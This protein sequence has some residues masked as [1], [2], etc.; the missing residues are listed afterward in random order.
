MT[1]TLTEARVARDAGVAVLDAYDPDWRECVDAAE[2]AM[3]SYSCCIM[4]QVKPGFFPEAIREISKGE[5]DAD[6]WFPWAYAH[7]FHSL[8]DGDFPVLQEAWLE[9][10]T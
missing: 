4:G 10:L 1:I 2:L 7:G 5:S 3:E 9:V 8:I 6:N